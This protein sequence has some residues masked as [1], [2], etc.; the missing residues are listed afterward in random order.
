MGVTEES[1]TFRLAKES[2]TERGVSRNPAFGHL[3]TE[4]AQLAGIWMKLQIIDCL[5]TKR[6]RSSPL[7]VDLQDLLGAFDSRSSWN[8]AGTAQGLKEEGVP[9]LRM[10]TAARMPGQPG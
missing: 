8:A 6:R 5:A 7:Y 9:F 1:E 3:S 2:H 4:L 10:F